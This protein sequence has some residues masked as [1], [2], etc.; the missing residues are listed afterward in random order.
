MNNKVKMDYFS[1]IKNELKAHFSLLLQDVKILKDKMSGAGREEELVHLDRMIKIN[2][3]LF[4]KL[5]KLLEIYTLDTRFSNV[6]RRK[7]SINKLLS[8]VSRELMRY[9][10]E[11]KVKIKLGLLQKDIYLNLYEEAI[12]NTLFWVLLNI[13]KHAVPSSDLIIIVNEEDKIV[14]IKISYLRKERDKTISNYR[15]LEF[16]NLILERYLKIEEGF[17]TIKSGDNGACE[18]I[19]NL[20]LKMSKDLDKSIPQTGKKIV[21]IKEIIKDEKELPSLSV[22]AAKVVSMATSDDVS[23]SQIAET[24]KKDPALTAKILKVV[25]SSFYGFRKQ[26]TT[27]SQAIAILGLSAVRTLSL[28]ISVLDRFPK[29]SDDSFNYQSFWERSLASAVASKII[30]GKLGEKETE[31]AF[32]AGLMQN[33]GGLIFA[34]YYPEEYAKILEEHYTLGTPIREMEK[35]KWGIDHAEIGNVL[36]T[37][38]SLPEILTKSIRYHHSP[39]EAKDESE[40]IRRT[41]NIV[42]LGDIIASIIY[43]VNKKSNLTLLREK[44]SQYFQFSEEDID[45]I[46]NKVSSELEEAAQNFEIS[47]SETKSYAEILQEANLEL[48]K[49]NL[50]YEQM[51]RELQKA[52]AKAEKLAEELQKANKK[53]KE[54]AITD[55]LTELYNHR[56]FFDLLEKEFSKSQR[57]KLPLSCI[58]MDIDFFK[59][60]NDTYGHKQG[61][62]VLKE[63][64]RILSESV[65]DGDIVA[66]YGGEEFSVILPKTEKE[67]ARI[68]AERIRRKI[69]ETAFPGGLEKGQ[70]TISLGTSTMLN[71]EYDTPGEL[72]EAADKAL[73]KAKENGRNR[74]ESFD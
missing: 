2:N 61:D 67:S 15:S 34:K 26:I 63:V 38:W 65:R 49:I 45:E 25:N 4:Q 29:K 16:E 22:V 73:Y 43:D 21:D 42:H 64:A 44:V 10:E 23:A 13:I 41:I 62:I 11:K 31:E 59:V 30:A 53:L 8:D 66:R 1:A 56:F 57:H 54:Q 37:K 52:I 48:G 46:M 12:K 3:S 33:I 18:L 68:V 24:I 14:K 28:C 36:S 5:D 69:E 17:Y 72:V 40:K 70:V 19:V 35:R 71:D 55:G 20:P 39:E 58:M 6:T 74:V 60:F 27:L 32:L 9:V 7:V 51:N 50:T 47:V